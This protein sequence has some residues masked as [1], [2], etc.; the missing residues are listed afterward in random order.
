MGFLGGAGG[1]D[2]NLEKESPHLPVLAVL[3]LNL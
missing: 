2:K 1:A 3:L